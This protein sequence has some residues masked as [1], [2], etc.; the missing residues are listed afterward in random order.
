MLSLPAMTREERLLAGL[1][2]NCAFKS[3]LAGAMGFGVGILFGLFTA[4]VDP[5]LTM[6]GG[7][8]TKQV[9]R[10]PLASSS[11]L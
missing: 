4:S 6:V 9:R 11:P 1:M 3:V 10:I 2:E 5:S 7:D 8:P